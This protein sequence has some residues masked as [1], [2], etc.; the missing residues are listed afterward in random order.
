MLLES[1]WSALGR[2]WRS[3]FLCAAA[4]TRGRAALKQHLAG[5]SAVEAKT[6]PFD[7][8]VLDYITA[9]RRSGGTTALVTASDRGFAEAIAAHLGV[10]DE[11]H[12]SDGT[13]NL[14]GDQ[15]A[16]LLVDRFGL[17]GFTYMGDA[18]A[19]LPVW[20]RAAKAVT[21]NASSTLRREAERV[22]G[23][24]EHLV[25]RVASFEPCLTAMRPYQ[26]LKNMLVFVPMLAAHQIDAT[27]IGQSVMAFI[28]FNLVASAVYILN[29]ML[30]LAADRDHPRKKHRPLA[31]GR[32]SISDGLWL[33][34]GLLL[35]GGVLSATL[36]GGYLLVMAAYFLLT[37]AYSLEFKH[38][39]VIDIC[40]LAGL[41]PLRLVAGSVATGI[42]LSDWLLGC[43]IF[44]FLSLA[45]V[46][47]QAELVESAQ[48]GQ[49]E[50]R[51]RGY[52][53]GDLPIV[54]MIGIGAGYL[55]VLAL[56]LYVT[57]P[58]VV[59]LY[60]QPEALFGVCAILLYWITRT[61]MITHRG[62]M[63]ENP[64]AFAARDRISQL[65]LLLIVFFVMLGAL[66]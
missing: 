58:E 40:V 57:V 35:L 53:V 20:A 45:A 43:S 44:L 30:D 52:R 15:K 55:G 12:G 63:R 49:L 33:A 38:R 46:K 37:A 6:L 32:L 41:Y 11:V 36:G 2:D 62:D 21:V 66:P 42:P 50:V 10:F 48:R 56:T 51:G 31:S 24:A 23:A 14:K 19:D 39:I 65:C 4:L 28:C 18:A 47:R 3:P 26:W 5:A 9:W 54:E 17:R 61:V 8:T 64:V 7:A 13:V 16:R 27:T 34:A 60:P 22:A 25:S 1:F 59:V 29:D